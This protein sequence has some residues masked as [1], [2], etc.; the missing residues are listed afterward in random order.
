M[1]KELLLA[2]ALIGAA[3]FVAIGIYNKLVR[4]R[5]IT[6]NSFGQIDVQI[7]RRHDLVPNLVEVARKYMAH[8]EDT[9]TAVIQA[10]SQATAAAAPARANPA[11]AQALG[12]LAKAEGSL[13]GAL[14]RLMVVTEAYPELKADAAMA[15]LSEEIS[16]SENRIAFARQAYNDSILDYNSLAEQF[17]NNVVALVCSFKSLPMLQATQSDAERQAPKVTFS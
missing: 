17:P 1:S 15:S 16:S 4:L 7:K 9:L 2:L 3:L 5:N 14:G 8:E 12:E 13:G 11:N 6:L 10:R